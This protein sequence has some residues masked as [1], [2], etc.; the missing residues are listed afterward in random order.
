[1]ASY[2]LAQMAYYLQEVSCLL[3]ETV[4]LGVA[5][6]G[7]QVRICPHGHLCPW[8]PILLPGAPD[9]LPFLGSSALVVLALVTDWHQVDCEMDCA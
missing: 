2:F 4:S 1:M 7:P 6:S 3:Q 9:L 5:T 8:S